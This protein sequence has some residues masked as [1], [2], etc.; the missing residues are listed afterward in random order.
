MLAAGN[1]PVTPVV[2][3]SP[4][5]FVSTPLVGVPISGVNKVAEVEPT[6]F[7]LPVLP[8]KGVLI[9]LFVA[10]NQSLRNS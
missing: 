1:K 10:I 9:E 2:N 7:P 3:G 4:V 5:Q 8:D 6:K